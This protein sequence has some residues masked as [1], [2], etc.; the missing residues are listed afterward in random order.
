M[1]RNTSAGAGNIDWQE[2][3]A[4]TIH[5]GKLENE[6][7]VGRPCHLILL[8]VMNQFYKAF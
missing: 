3:V 7:A 1:K 5:M 2:F 8:S 6:E 4:A